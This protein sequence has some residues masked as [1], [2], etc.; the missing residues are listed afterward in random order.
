MTTGKP[1]ALTRRTF[2]GK[3]MSLL[4]NI[5]PR[6]T[7]NE[8]QQSWFICNILKSFTIEENQQKKCSDLIIKFLTVLRV[9]KCIIDLHVVMILV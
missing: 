8:K 1:I 4:L 6:K 9:D 3:V 5:L 7:S 2:V